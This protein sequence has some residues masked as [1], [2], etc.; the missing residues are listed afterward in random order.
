MKNITIGGNL[1]RDA[2]VRTT[3]NGDKVAGFSVAV[4]DRD[5]TI[6][7]R[8]DLWGTRAEKLAPYLR[9]GT[10]V[11]VNGD[12][13]LSEYEGKTQ[14]NIRVNDVL[15]QG[16]KRSDEPGERVDDRPQQ[17]PAPMVDEIPF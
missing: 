4:K 15:L 7:F 10:P 8:C 16:G 17:R 3:Q 2:E 14:L 9:K 6:W 11:T 12:L 5:E 13:R 1:G